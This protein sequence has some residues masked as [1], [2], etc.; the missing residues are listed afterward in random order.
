[1]LCCQRRKGNRHEARK[2]VPR[3]PE[4][5]AHYE[6]TKK[7]TTRFTVKLNHNTDGDVL[8]HLD[9]QGN[10]QSYIKQLIREDMKRKT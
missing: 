10:K 4:S 7:N 2:E 1:M 9:K 8:E 6:W 5:K 3:V